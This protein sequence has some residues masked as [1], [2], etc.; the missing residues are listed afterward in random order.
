M[1]SFC[2]HTTT[3]FISEAYRAQFITINPVFV[4][5]IPHISITLK[6]SIGNLIH[7]TSCFV[8]KIN[9]VVFKA[10][11][12]LLRIDILTIIFLLSSLNCVFGLEMTLTRTLTQVADQVIF[13]IFVIL[14]SFN[15]S[16]LS[17]FILFI[18]AIIFFFN[19]WIITNEGMLQD[20]TATWMLKILE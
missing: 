12:F 6:H 5:L 16:F 19:I 14:I 1:I 20:H 2:A 7:F 4:E 9:I 18:V 17:V 15:V 13:G 10:K 3:D 11:P 8:T